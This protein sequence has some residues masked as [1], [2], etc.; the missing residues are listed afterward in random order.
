MNPEDSKSGRYFKNDKSITNLTGLNDLAEIIKC[1]L[2]LCLHSV[3]PLA[4]A[5]NTNIF[6]IFT[7]TKGSNS[8]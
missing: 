4:T 3:S 2:Q 8:I 6:S 1:Y 7:N 5:T